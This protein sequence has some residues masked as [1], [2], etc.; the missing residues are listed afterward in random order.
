MKRI[1]HVIAAACL[2][3][4]VSLQ[5]HATWSVIVIDPVTKTIGMAGAS[6]TYSVY[7]IGGIIPGKG[8][9]IVQAM[10]NKAAK[11]KGLQMIMA[12]APPEQILAALKNPYFDPEEQQYAIVCVNYP[13]RAIT[14]TGEE[15]TP[16]NGALTAKGIS[17]QG[18]TLVTEKELIAALDA[19]L[20]AQEQSL[21]MEEIL[22]QALEAGAK[23]GGDKRCGDRK[24][25]SAF[26]TVS[27]ATDNVQRPSIN[28]IVNQ[29]DESSNAIVTLRKRL[30]EWKNNHRQ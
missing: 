22:M 21:P 14:Y 25:A 29:T 26:I 23:L 2:I 30:N 28:L 16:A 4:V 1:K 9:V 18:N 19:A 11:A 5:A 8:A 20:K 7:G 27:K 3:I 24:A 17:V 10:S 12:N 13:T 15:T 6:C